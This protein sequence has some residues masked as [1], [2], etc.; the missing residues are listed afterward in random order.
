MWHI[1]GRGEEHAGFLCC[2]LM[3]RGHLDNLDK[4]EIIILKEVF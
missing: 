4:S 2:N 1:L 3:E